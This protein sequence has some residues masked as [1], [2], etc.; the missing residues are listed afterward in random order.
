MTARLSALLSVL[1][2]SMAYGDITQ[3]KS[4]PL[5]YLLNLDARSY[6]DPLSGFPVFEFELP[7]GSWKVAFTNPNLT[8]GAAYYGWSP[9][10][11][12]NLWGSSVDLS[13]SPDR[14]GTGASFPDAQSAFNDVAGLSW[15]FSTSVTLPI[16]AYFL[17]NKIDDNRGGVSLTIERQTEVPEA[18]TGVGGVLVLLIASS[19]ALRR[20]RS[21]HRNHTHSTLTPGLIG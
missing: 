12:L 16:E 18:S 10:A 5:T 2:S 11:S 14:I 21:P 13:P 4:E 8:P 9:F 7:P 6:G 3:I 17:D 20:H 19:I 1:V 15:T